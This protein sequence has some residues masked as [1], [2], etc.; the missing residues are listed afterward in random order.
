[1]LPE[2]VSL[3]PRTRE[4]LVRLRREGISSAVVTNGTSAS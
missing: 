3:D 2:F 4:L 1:M